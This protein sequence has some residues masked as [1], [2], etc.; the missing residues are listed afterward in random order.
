MFK[1]FQW[2][3]ILQVLLLALL[4]SCNGTIEEEEKL[5]VMATTPLLEDWVNNVA[6]GRVSVESIIPYGACLL[7][8][9]PSTR[10]RG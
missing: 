9:S 10:D 1:R 8:T 7:Y 6:E 3:L 4:V 2:I 5:K